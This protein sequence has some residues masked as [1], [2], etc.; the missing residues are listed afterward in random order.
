[1]RTRLFVIMVLALLLCALVVAPS[2]SAYTK[3][4][5]KV[6]VRGAPI[7]GSNGLAVDHNGRLLVASG[8]GGQI[9]AL[10][11]CTGRVL[12]R[13]GHEVGVDGP[14][15]VAVGPDGSIY[16]TDFMAGD[17]GRLTPEGVFTKQL[18]AP[19][20]NPIAFTADGRLFVGQ[21]F[22]GD[23]LFELDPELVAPPRV[24]IPSSG[25]P[26]FLGQLNG[27]DFGPDGM[28]YSP[29]PF[30][31]RVIK[32][33]P[34]TGVIDPTPVA[35][36]SALGLHPSS[37]EFD[38]QGHLYA[39]L[40]DGLMIVRIDLATGAFEEVA[41]ISEGEIDNM[42]FDAGDRL[43][44]SNSQT[45][46]IYTVRSCGVRTLSR[47]GLMLPGGIAL[48]KGADCRTTLF[49]ADMWRLVR[50]DPYSG[51]PLG[52]DQ[53]SHLGGTII[54]SWTVAADDGNVIV[55][56]FTSNAV[57]IWDPVAGQAVEVFTDFAVPLNAIRFQGDLVVAE[58][59]TGSVVSKDAETGAK[60]TLA[61]GLAVPTGLAATDDDLWVADWAT[62]T[63]WQIVADGAV[64]TTPKALATGLMFPEGMAVAR[65]NHKH[66]L[67]VESGTGRLLRIDPTSGRIRTLAC[68]LAT[69][70]PG[71]TGAPPEWALASVAVGAHGTIYV[72]G[73]VANVIYRL[74]PLHHHCD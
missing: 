66:L 47:G 57:Q 18:V 67:V 42:C 8:L 65:D 55:S 11:R 27:F 17:V 32:V 22:M 39:S 28:L 41:R 73:D 30:M 48:M 74:R 10:D 38:S 33:D 49:V 51:C 62:G 15:D 53:Y 71:G 20:M 52:W 44:F 34:D 72:S 24:V 1:M 40:A 58:L 46:A 60:T 19:G 43:Y 45:G 12:E 13:L 54:Q 7:H 69:G 16:W 29:Q 59:G 36:F 3:Y 63:I 2:A 5:C 70:L 50:F 37:V 14:D 35:D 68:G 23:A 61:S 6:F 31:M 64:L 4:D 25:V 21:G 26:P 9:V 56:S